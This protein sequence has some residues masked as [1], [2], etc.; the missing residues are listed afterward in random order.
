MLGIPLRESS[1]LRLTQEVGSEMVEHRDRQV[2]EH[3]RRVLKPRHQIIPDAVVVEVDGG[4]M[5]TR[6]AHAA[7]GVHDPQNK[8]DKIAG[9]F[10]EAHVTILKTAISPH[11]PIQVNGRFEYSHLLGHTPKRSVGHRSPS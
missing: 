8:E 3:R 5:R 10:E 4:R 9:I 11:F 1:V 6:A 7:P 2:M